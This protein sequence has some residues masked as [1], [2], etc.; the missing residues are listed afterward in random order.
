MKQRFRIVSLLCSG[1]M[2]L[3]AAS[4]PA[5]TQPAS[6]EHGTPQM[7][8]L[9]D[10]RLH[11]HAVDDGR[12][13]WASDTAEAPGSLLLTQGRLWVT[14]SADLLEFEASTGQVLRRYAMPARLFTPRVSGDRLLLAD[15]SGQLTVLDMR[16]GD[17]LWRRRL[18]QRWVYPPAVEGARLYTGGAD[19]AVLALDRDKG[20]LLW[21]QDLGQELVYSPVLTA[22]RLWVPTFDGHLRGLEPASGRI[23]ID[24][25]LETPLFALSAEQGRLIGADYGGWLN[26]FDTESGRLLWRRRVA[27]RA[28]FDFEL[29]ASWLLAAAP[30]GAVQLLHADDGHI[31]K[32]LR[33]EPDDPGHAVIQGSM[34]WLFPT[35]Q[36][37]Q[38]GSLRPVGWPLPAEH[39]P[40]GEP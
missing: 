15:A 17:T 16:S 33:F 1:W 38:A 30:S 24:R 22:G 36:S 19:G 5:A 11:C 39:S 7:L 32:R 10:T 28:P 21:R 29:S 18:S 40:G 31:L 26:A 13:L 25:R 23:L 14:Q 34:V 8:C 6:A 20:R 2:M 4:V 3:S 37:S 35:K 27:D 9:L 12:E